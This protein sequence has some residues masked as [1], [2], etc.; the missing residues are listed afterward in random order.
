MPQSLS[1]LGFVLVVMALPFCFA[2][3]QS[4]LQPVARFAMPSDVQGRFDHL[5]IDE[6]G[7]RL[8]VAAESAHEVL[9]FD[10]H[11]GRFM[12]A[13]TGIEIPHAIFV[14]EDLNRIY[15]TDGGAGD[16]KVYDG[17]TYAL[18]RSI[19]LKVDSDSIGYDP[20]TGYLYVDNGGG[21]AHE[22]FSMLSVVDT[23]RN[24]KVA[25]IR[26]HG[27]TLEAMALEKNTDKM[28]VNDAALNQVVV[29]DRKDRSILATWPVEKGKRN[30][31][32]ALDETDHRL[33]VASRSGVISVFDTDSQKELSSLP[34]GP[35]VDD[36]SFDPSEKRLY[37]TCGGDGL[38]Y[39]FQKLDGDQYVLAGKVPTGPGGKNGLL[40]VSLGRFY[41][42]VPPRGATPGS[43]Y[44]YALR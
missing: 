2:N 36:L 33:F 16:V 38:I 43:V 26:I 5:G 23:T 17:Q 9:V 24:M 20:A 32:M 22:T 28:Y 39:V 15:V 11:S 25:D 21:D 1:K 41:V 37:A 27:D 10:L 34:I 40:S 14:R 35:G 29:L 13:I 12:R 44:A 8:F 19:P 42:I 31:A 18:V 6:K 4:P 7:G 30:V 3:A